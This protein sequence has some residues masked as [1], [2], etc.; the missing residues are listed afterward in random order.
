MWRGEDVRMRK[1]EDEKM[2]RWEDVRVRRCEDEKM[3]GWEDEIQTPHYWKNPAL[4][5][6]RE[7][8]DKN[9]EQSKKEEPFTEASL[10]NIEHSA[11]H[12]VFLSG[13]VQSSFGFWMLLAL[14][15]S[16]PCNE[17]SKKPCVCT[18]CIDVKLHYAAGACGTHVL[19]HAMKLWTWVGWETWPVSCTCNFIY[20]FS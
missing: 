12:A 18:T 11:K 17:K 2:W 19:P 9:K 14:L 7:N 5:R 1:C 10:Q 6:S 8:L 16:W 4:R 13:E 15:S 20:L 3:W